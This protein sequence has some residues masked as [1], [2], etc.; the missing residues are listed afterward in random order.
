M[1]ILV[2]TVLHRQAGSG[3]EFPDPLE[4]RDEQLVAHFGSR[5]PA[6]GVQ[7]G[8]PDARPAPEPPGLHGAPGVP[9]FPAGGR[10]VNLGGRLARRR[11]GDHRPLVV[12]RAE[13]VRHRNR[14]C[15]PD[16]FSALITRSEMPRRWAV[17]ECT[18]PDVPQNTAT[19]HAQN[20]FYSSAEKDGAKDG[21]PNGLELS[22][23]NVARQIANAASLSSKSSLRSEARDISPQEEC[24]STIRCHVLRADVAI[25][26]AGSTAFAVC[27]VMGKRSIA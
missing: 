23:F 14:H 7:R 24:N 21:F 18:V 13:S 9:A 11:E 4:R 25:G 19:A 27:R 22:C 15:I 1:V 16:T 6:P 8:R 12:S 2:C 20:A 5:L 26:S 17:D 3:T 10:R